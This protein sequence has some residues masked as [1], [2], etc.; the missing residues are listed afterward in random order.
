MW[1]SDTVGFD[2]GPLTDALGPHRGYLGAHRRP[3]RGEIP[4]AVSLHLQR[5]WRRLVPAHH[6]PFPT[7]AGVSM[8]VLAM[9]G[10]LPPKLLVVA[11]HTVWG[12][13]PEQSTPQLVG[14]LVY[15]T[16][17]CR[18]LDICMESQGEDLPGWPLTAPEPQCPS[19]PLPCTE[20]SPWPQALPSVS[21]TKLHTGILLTYL[22]WL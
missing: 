1:A 20:P 18:Y 16:A 12:F 17:T 21:L 4:T 15:F 22:A 3:K 19:A 7:R 6:T 5:K 14:T 10:P 13:L 8:A 2:M 9:R 11:V